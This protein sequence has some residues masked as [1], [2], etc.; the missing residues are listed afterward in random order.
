MHLLNTLINPALKDALR[1]F[2]YLLSWLFQSQVNVRAG[3]GRNR[4]NI[5]LEFSSVLH[6]T[7]T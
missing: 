3:G 1:G 5:P 7:S 4:F 6:Y 2:R